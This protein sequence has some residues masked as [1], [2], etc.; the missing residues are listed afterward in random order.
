MTNVV[1]SQG[2]KAI[3]TFPIFISHYIKLTDR[4]Q[5]LDNVLKILGFTNVHWFEHINRDT[6]TSDQ[7]KMYEYNPEK[8]MSL[9]SVW[10]EYKSLPRKLSGPEI[11]N[12]LT[13]IEIYKYIIDNNI[14]TALILEDDCI[15]YNTQGPNEVRTNIYNDKNEFLNNLL[16]SNL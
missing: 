9:N 5:Y 16:K 3:Q 14:Q 13:H 4:K 7:L 6:L 1:R 12:E 15:L 2:P 11:A 8:W 10:H